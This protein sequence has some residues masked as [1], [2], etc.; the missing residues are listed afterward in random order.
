MSA[1]RV[2]LGVFVALGLAGCGDEASTYEGGFAGLDEVY[3]QQ[4]CETVIDQICL[5]L[6]ACGTVA[7]EDLAECVLGI[8]TSFPCDRAVDTQP[9][10]PSCLSAL[11]SGS[12]GPAL[13]GELPAACVG[14]I[15]T[16]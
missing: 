11:Q 12:C 14:V 4:R 1:G 9:S 7:S 15:L 2:A 8:R 3:A 10:Y 16:R 13:R 5:Y 6:E